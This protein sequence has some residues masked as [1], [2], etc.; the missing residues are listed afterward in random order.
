MGPQNAQVLVHV[1]DHINSVQRL[2]VRLYFGLV[3]PKFKNLCVALVV[4]HLNA[5]AINCARE[6]GATQCTRHATAGP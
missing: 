2:R 6:D 5:A 1:C 3:G 4:F